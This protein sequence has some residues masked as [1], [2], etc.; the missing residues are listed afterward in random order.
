MEV[1]HLFPLTTILLLGPFDGL[2]V[3]VAL[4]MQ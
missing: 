2:V 1:Q 4:G 3:A